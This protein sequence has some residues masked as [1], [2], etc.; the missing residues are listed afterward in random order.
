[1]EKYRRPIQRVILTGC[2]LFIFA[3]VILFSIQAQYS[4]HK[5]LYERYDAKLTE[6]LTFIESQTDNDD[7]MECLKTGVHSE[8]YDRLQAM[9]NDMVDDMDLFY[10]Y[11]VIPDSENGLMHN[12]CSATSDA[13]RA[14][15]AVDLEIHETSDA[16]EIETLK[17]Y[18]NC[19]DYDDV[20][21]FE[22]ISEW[23]DCYTACKPMHDSKGNFICLACADI[24]ASVIKHTIRRY[25]MMNVV[26]ALVLGSLFSL[27]IILWLNRNIVNP[28]K[29]LEESARAYIKTVRGKSDPESMVFH[30]PEINTDNEIQSLSNTIN[31]M[32]I[33]MKNNVE[34]II[35]AEEKVKN[36]KQ[37]VSNM[38]SLAYID[39]LTGVKNATALDKEKE[40]LAKNIEEGKPFA[41]VMIDLNDLKGINDTYGHEAG[42]EFI[43]GSC[44][45]I[46]QVFKHSPVY[47]IGGD[48]FLTVLRGEDFNNREQLLLDLADEYKAA[49]EAE[50]DEPWKRYSAAAGIAVYGEKENDTMEAVFKRADEDMYKNKELLKKEMSGK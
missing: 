12:A 22:E 15:G 14:E 34:A 9:L 31:Q 39:K 17:K 36:A 50:T 20:S 1:M 30:A 29:K 27:F 28:V 7:L 26:L 19:M 33:V 45:I 32:S 41:L 24:E 37:E 10:L 49:C 11:L 40:K 18:E 25:A 43:V 47:R 13:E 5:A 8:K 38:T 21:F 4:I 2:I 6:V 23:G 42:N 44:Q 16:Y 46:C 48:E 3:M 35:S